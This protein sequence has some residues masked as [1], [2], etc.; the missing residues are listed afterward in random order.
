MRALPV[1]EK[2]RLVG[3]ITRTDL[4]RALSQSEE[5]SKV[6]VKDIMSSSPLCVAEDAD[7]SE[8]RRI[9]ASLHER[10][11]P[12]VDKDRNLVGMIGLKDLTQ[13]FASSKHKERKGEVVGK[14]K[15]PQIRVG[16]IMRSPAITLPPDGRFGDALKLML[17]NEISSI[18]ISQSGE[19]TGLVTKADV[20]EFLASFKKREE[21]LVKISGLEEQPDVYDQIYE[22][23]R[24]S[25]KRIKGIVTPKIF[26]LH[27]VTYKG[28]G[29]RI[30][31]S[32]R[33]R[34]TTS[35]GLIYAK[36]F[37]WDLFIALE[38]LLDQLETRIK[39]EKDKRVGRRR[40]GS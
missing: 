39:K 8:A 1:C 5:V 30:K 14:S 26:T 40:R 31:W 15:A 9:M 32:L 34:F 25:M 19:P 16:S 13:F 6:I 17:D 10:A 27:V 29:D 20:L 2:K 22:V 35:S 12:V 7:V 28:D 23:I 4:T 11:V 33:C 38:G 21:L 36:H 3:I 37:D 24:K 18:M